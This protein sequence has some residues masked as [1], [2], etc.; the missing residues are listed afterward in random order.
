M[1]LLQI[2]RPSKMTEAAPTVEGAFMRRPIRGTFPWL[3]AVLLTAGCSNNN[4]LN[5]TPTT[6]P[7]TVTD[8]F[9]GSVNVNGAIT[10][11]FGVQTG[12][13]VT[14]TLKTLDPEDAVIGLSLGTWNGSACQIV[15]AN[16]SAKL[17]TIVIGNVTSL[18]NL[19]VRL[20]DVGSFTRTT[21]YEVEVVHP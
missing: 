20:Y 5:P 16:D 13:R 12:G 18:G 6:P 19:C 3:F 10:H 7:V 15:L 1:I 4:T 2:L 14:A 11:A 9:S 17:G 21:S 8:T